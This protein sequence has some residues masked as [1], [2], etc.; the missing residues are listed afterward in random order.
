[1]A[2][3]LKLREEH[4]MEPVGYMSYNNSTETA[5]T[6]RMIRSAAFITIAAALMSCVFFYFEEDISYAASGMAAP[7]LKKLVYSEPKQGKFQAVLN[8]KAKK[9]YYYQV[10][11]KTSKSGKYKQ[12]AL[13][14][15]SSGTGK[16]KDTSI[17]KNKAYT[18]T[19]RRVKV[20]GKKI[21][22]KGKYDS[23]GLTTL[24]RPA[25]TVDFTN[26][27]GDLS[28]KKVSGATNYLVFRRVGKS[29]KFYEI[30]KL[31][32]GSLKYTDWWYWS[33]KDLKSKSYSKK[34]ASIISE[35]LRGYFMDASNNPVSYRVQAYS[36]KKAGGVLK[37]SYGL[38]LA[39]GEF[40]L[41]TPAIIS[42]SDEGVLKW[43]HVA[44]AEG[45]RIETSEDGAD[46]DKIADVKSKGKDFVPV[47][48]ATSA[49]VYQEYVID[50]FD[51]GRYYSVSAYADKNGSRIYSA[52]DTGFTVKDRGFDENVLYVGD[53]ISYG[54][55]YYDGEKKVFAYQNRIAEMTGVTFFNPSIPGATYHFSAKDGAAAEEETDT[56]TSKLVTGVMQMVVKG[57]ITDKIMTTTAGLNKSHLYDYDVVV[58]AGGTND[59][60]HFDKDTFSFG[61]R[62]TDWEKIEESAKT[63]DLKFTVN[64]GTTYSRTYRE[65]YDYNI[66][67]FDGAYN[68]IMKWI[69][70]ASVYRVQ[71]GKKPIQVV[72]MSIFYSD[73]AK[74]PYYVPTNRDKTPNSLGLTLKDYQAELDQ[75][76]AAWA[77]SAGM[78]VYT[79]DTRGEGIL[80]SKTCPYATADNLHLT[81]AT[82][83]R[84]GNS[85]SNFMM[86]SFLGKEEDADIGSPEFIKLAGKHGLLSDRLEYLEEQAAIETGIEDADALLGIGD[87][88]AELHPAVKEMKAY[89]DTVSSLGYLEAML[90][91]CTD[92]QRD[93]YERFIASYELPETEVE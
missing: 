54:S 93:R 61:D 47:T 86:S 16:Y 89:I 6:R 65:S 18:Y 73:R 85:L 88:E 23:E 21:K 41:E 74:S 79:Y 91:E 34:L 45:Y 17:G 77:G 11:R 38:Y 5:G 49:D 57:E 3:R 13:I 75:L 39:D 2:L 29:D 81:K 90:G 43:G 63:N 62:E 84:F 46:W 70:E 30:K 35:R 22:E 10:L 42:L 83:A 76:N 32:S 25:L 78:K 27:K 68:Q 28:W 33:T 36:S 55:P 80:N 87:P 53:S 64:Y 71:H 44:N 92:E 37:E 52:R 72:A 15:A 14:K 69:E 8:W 67:T 40:R 20:Q 12:A 1:M 9:G 82:Y 24:K 31:A 51:R 60:L 26:L 7:A 66:M 56:S 59:Y 4:G 50:G 58:L 48:G 19:V